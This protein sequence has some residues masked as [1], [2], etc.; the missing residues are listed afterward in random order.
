MNAVWMPSIRGL[1]MSP[2]LGPPHSAP[3]LYVRYSQ[4]NPD[5]MHA[6]H[7]GGR[8]QLPI[9]TYRLRS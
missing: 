7:S 1:W 8:V 6:L 5:I 4:D 3:G 2:A 9:D